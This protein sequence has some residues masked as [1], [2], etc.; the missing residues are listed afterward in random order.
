MQSAKQQAVRAVH[1]RHVMVSLLAEVAGRINAGLTPEQVVVELEKI[2]YFARID[3]R[4]NEIKRIESVTVDAA[5]DVWSKNNAGKIVLIAE[6][7]A[8]LEAEMGTI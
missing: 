2:A 4:L 7:R 1:P 8:E 6:R 5:I 3:G